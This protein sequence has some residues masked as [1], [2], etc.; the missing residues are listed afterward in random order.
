[1]TTDEADPAEQFIELMNSGRALREDGQASESLQ[2]FEAAIRVAPT[3]GIAHFD[4]AT[5]LHHLGENDKAEIAYDL[6]LA[7]LPKGDQERLSAYLNRASI[8]EEA[9]DITGAIADLVRAS[10]LGAPD[11]TEA[12][13]EALKEQRDQDSS[14]ANR[15]RLK[16]QSLFD[17]GTSHLGSSPFMALALLTEV[18]E[19]I[20]P[21]SNVFYARGLANVEVRRLGP[22][23]EDFETT[24][25]LE[26][27]A[28]GMRGEALFN[29]GSLLQGQ[30]RDEE[31]LAKYRECRDLAENPS[32]DFPRIDDE[33][34]A[35]TILAALDAK[36]DHLSAFDG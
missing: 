3:A 36:I 22:A 31:A 11:G 15:E 26:T 29:Y 35:Q 17:Q 9:D 33:A 32:V 24:L 20:P 30:G 5:V 6:A 23:M 7:M 10:A 2:Q 27:D 34:K 8:R 13:L 18:A 28:T 19:R 21:L 12:R 14:S 4:R 1:M 25:K 16:L